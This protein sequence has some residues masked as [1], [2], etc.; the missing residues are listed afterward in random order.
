MKTAIKVLVL[1]SRIVSLGILKV[2][3]HKLKHEK[4]FCYLLTIYEE[5]ELD[6]ETHQ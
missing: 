1:T 2:F 4:L 6:G 5:T 3:A